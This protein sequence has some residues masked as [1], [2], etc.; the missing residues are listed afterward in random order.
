VI[1]RIQLRLRYKFGHLKK[2][3]YKKICKQ[4]ANVWADN[5]PVL[6]KPVLGRKP[7]MLGLRYSAI[8]SFMVIVYPFSGPVPFLTLCIFI[9][10]AFSFYL[11]KYFMLHYYKLKNRYDNRMIRYILDI[12]KY[13][14]IVKLL[15]SIWLFPR[16]EI[17]PPD[18]KLETIY[19]I[20]NIISHKVLWNQVKRAAPLFAVLIIL[21]CFMVFE[22]AL[23]WII[24]KIYKKIHKNEKEP[25]TFTYM[26]ICKA[27]Q[28]TGVD[29]P[30]NYFLENNLKYQELIQ[31][32]VESMRPLKAD[33]V[34]RQDRELK[35]K[36]FVILGAP[37]D[38][39]DNDTE[40]DG[41]LSSFKMGK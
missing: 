21:L 4:S 31:F 15:I 26:E 35:P 16:D 19:D 8:L 39:E 27:M 12:F 2:T 11:H 37:V 5:T 28:E 3:S 29:R 17:F 9:S 23:F 13:I 33:N 25:E 40:I 10:F 1:R 30:K 14:L 32:D 20:K 6:K 24:D 36:D 22:G 7:F 18:H 38:Y 34:F 41:M